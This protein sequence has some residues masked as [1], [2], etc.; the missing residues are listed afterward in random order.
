MK[1]VHKRILSTCGLIAPFIF[2]GTAVIG[3]ALRPGYSHLTDTVSELFS[4]GSPNKPL[5][6]SLYLVFAFLLIGF[7]VSI[8]VTV[9]E[10]ASPNKAG[11][12]GA[13]LYITVGILHVFSAVLFPQDPWGSTLTFPGMMHFN[14][15]GIITIFSLFSMISLGFWFKKTGIF[16]EFR[17]YTAITIILA[18]IASVFFM[19]NLGTQIMGLA[20]RIA[21]LIGFQWI[22]V[23]SL[24][25][26]KLSY[27][28][29]ENPGRSNQQ[30]SNT[31]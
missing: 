13:Y 11:K 27:K 5:L 17:F 3:G 24:W 22:F 23:L 31:Y 26:F 12:I 20:E 29:V 9:G 15:H 8:L 4:P 18:V 21:A 7:G 30:Q 19:V 2:I 10:S 1:T 14:I 28:H 6:D 16:P 25:M